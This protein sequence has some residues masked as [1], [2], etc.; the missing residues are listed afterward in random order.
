MADNKSIFNLSY[1]QDNPNLNSLI[2]QSF[3]TITT[4]DIRVGYI[5][6]ELGYVTNVTICEANDYAQ[7]NPATRFVLPFFLPTFNKALVYLRSFLLERCTQP[8][9]AATK[10]CC[11]GVK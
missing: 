2:N 1:N 5:D 7:K 3:Q 8:N 6:P 11:Q 10:N 9:M 4:G